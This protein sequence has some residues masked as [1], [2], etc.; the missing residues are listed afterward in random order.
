[1]GSDFWVITSFFNPARYKTKRR[2]FDAFS[3]G[4]KAAGANLLV[5]E[6]AFG[7]SSFELEPGKHVLQVRG[8]GTMWQKERLLNVAAARLPSSCRKVGWFDADIV[9]KEPDWLERTCEALD[10]Y[11]VVQP[12]SQAVQLRRGN[13]DD[14]SGNFHESFASM[15][16]R[17]P[18]QARTAVG[19]RHGH[20]GYAW[21]ARR[22]LFEQCGLYDACLNGGADHLMAH[23]FTAAMAR[24]PCVV[25]TFA[26]SPLYADHFFRWGVTARD[27]VGSSLG[28]VPGR[29]LHLWHGD[30]VDRRYDL[31][32]RQFSTLGFDPDKHLRHDSNGMLEWTANAPE[33][34]KA[35]A[36]DLFHSRNEDGED[37]AESVAIPEAGPGQ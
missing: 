8:D 30:V 3:A 14:G 15:F 31:L 1:M 17:N 24:S 28:V 35:W 2:N 29:I 27:V 4:M 11:V 23:A 34:L 6:M 19:W 18:R 10:R 9:F 21:A 22:D 37:A 32:R 16:V 12:F 26:Q 36:R 5:V 13:R 25:Q 20:T 7:D 33:D